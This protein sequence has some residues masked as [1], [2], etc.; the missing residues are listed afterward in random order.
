MVFFILAWCMVHGG[1]GGLKIMRCR[2]YATLCEKTLVWWGVQNRAAHFLK[3]E[4]TLNF[5]QITTFDT[6]QKACSVV[7]I[8]LTFCPHFVTMGP[9]EP[10]VIK[11]TK[12]LFY[13][14]SFL[15]EF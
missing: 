2:G 1:G 11:G 4:A 10:I 12:A 13:N 9:L 6:S 8:S 15:S 3:A 7:L 5:D 14:T